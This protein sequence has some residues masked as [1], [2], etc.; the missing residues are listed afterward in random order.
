MIFNILNLFEQKGSLGTLVRGVSC[1][2]KVTGSSR[3]IGHWK[4]VRPLIIYPSWCGP[5]SNSKYAGCFV[6][7]TD[8]NLFARSLCLSCIILHQLE[9]IHPQVFEMH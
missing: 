2:L 9:K 8:L 3:G 6:H 4:Q 5:S 1:D 7:H